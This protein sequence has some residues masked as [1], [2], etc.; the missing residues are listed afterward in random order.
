MKNAETQKIDV[1][2]YR[3]TQQAQSD[4]LIA[5]FKRGVPVRYF[6]ET[7]EYRD[8]SRIW[9]SWNMDRMYASGIPMRVRAPEQVGE[10]HENEPV[11]Q[12]TAGAQLL[13]DEDLDLPVVRR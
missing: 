12:F 8:T 7:R 2:M 4:A 11:G 10:N 13:H 3:V 1:I 6:G 5:A 9:V